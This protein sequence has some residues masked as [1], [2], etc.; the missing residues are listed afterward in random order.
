MKRVG[1]AGI[2]AL[3][4]F[5]E[6]AVLA[7]VIAQQDANAST[8]HAMTLPSVDQHVKLLSERLELTADQ[9]EKARPIIAEMQEALQKTMDDKSLTPE[10]AHA[11]MHSAFMKADKEMRAFLTDEQKTKLD[12]MEREHREGRE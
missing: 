6:L 2:A 12:E 1:F 8:K 3:A 9:Q 11:Q 7:P 4:V 5:A 10:D